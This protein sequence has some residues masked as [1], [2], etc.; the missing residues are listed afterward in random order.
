M[1]LADKASAIS[2]RYF[3]SLF[4]EKF[5]NILLLL[6]RDFSRYA[7]ILRKNLSTCFEF[8]FFFLRSNLTENNILI[9]W[10]YRSWIKMLQNWRFTYVEFYTFFFSNI[11]IY[12]GTWLKRTTNFNGDLNYFI[13]LH[14]Y[15]FEKGKM[16]QSRKENFFNSHRMEL[17][18]N[19]CET[20]NCTFNEGN[21]S[22]DDPPGQKC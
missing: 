7:S 14:F 20:N 13:Q 1:V 5:R 22:D 16:L 4:R 15:I 9:K 8:L 2:S 11:F 6:T 3:F 10:R 21:T 17:T 18:R 19:S 12:I